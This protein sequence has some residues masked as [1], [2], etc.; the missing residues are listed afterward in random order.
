GRTMKLRTI[1][2]LF[3]A[4]GLTSAHAFEEI[5]TGNIRGR[6]TGT[7]SFLSWIEGP[8]S[9]GVQVGPS[10]YDADMNLRQKSELGLGAVVG[11]TFETRIW[12]FLTVQPELM[13]VQKSV[14]VNRAPG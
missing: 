6:D 14:A 9:V 10:F 13:S 3:L 1:L 12:R 7:V 8:M 11:A 2:G 4:F 5:A